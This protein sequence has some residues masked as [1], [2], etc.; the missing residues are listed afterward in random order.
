MKTIFTRLTPFLLFIISLTFTHCRPE[1]SA[2]SKQPW[3]Q[4][5]IRLDGQIITISRQNGYPVYARTLIP[6]DTTEDFVLTKE[7]KDSIYTC[8]DELI[9]NPVVPKHY[10]NAGSA[11]M[12][13]FSVNY[14]QFETTT[15]YKYLKSWRELSDKTEMLYSI[16]SRKIKFLKR[17]HNL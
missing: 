1:E 17:E 6:N 4:I 11:D 16:L 10:I 14:K 3:E 8:V 2:N 12:V 15:D 7:Q 13:S 5:T 9:K